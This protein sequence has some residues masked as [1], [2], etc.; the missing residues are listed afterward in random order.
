M[1][2]HVCVFCSEELESLHRELEVLSEQ[3]SQK[4]LENAH[5]SRTIETERQALSST[6]RENQ[7]LY[8]RNQVNTS[9]A[10]TNTCMNTFLA[11]QYIDAAFRGTKCFQCLNLITT[12]VICLSHSDSVKP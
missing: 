5:L 1:C 9:A 3:Y 11:R 2:V 12:T 6:E 10:H 8:K 7:E 4:C